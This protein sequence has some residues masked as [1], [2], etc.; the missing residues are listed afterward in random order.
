MLDNTF[1]EEL[2]RA[3]A[4]GEDIEITIDENGEIE[5]EM[6]YE[7]FMYCWNKLKEDA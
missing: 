7:V 4:N 5:F 2:Q 3:A 1:F 6:D